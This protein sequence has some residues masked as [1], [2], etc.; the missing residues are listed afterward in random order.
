MRKWITASIN[1]VDILIDGPA[2]ILN[3]KTSET[4]EE[5]R[6]FSHREIQHCAAHGALTM[7]QTGMKVFVIQ[8][9]D[10]AWSWWSLRFARADFSSRNSTSLSSTCDKKNSQ[11]WC[12]AVI[13][14]Q[15]KLHCLKQSFT[16]LPRWSD[17]SKLLNWF[18]SKRPSK[19]ESYKKKSTNDVIKHQN[20]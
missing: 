15:R 20:H 4:R 1:T 11:L 13:I 10:W 9:L 6:T 7:E 19:S 14:P 3:I 8:T 17:F 12:T 5:H 2:A 18:L 16:I